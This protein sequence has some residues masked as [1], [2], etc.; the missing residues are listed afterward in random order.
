[1]KYPMVPKSSIY[2]L[3]FL[4][5]A[6]PF[7]TFAQSNALF[8]D[9]KV[10][11]ILIE[12]N[13]ADL[14][15]VYNTGGTDQYFPARFIFVDGAI[16]DTV[17]N[18]GFR[19]RGNTSLSSAKKSFKVAFNTYEPGR[20]YQDVKKINL[21]GNHN[22]PTMIREKLYYDIWNRFGLPER[23]VAF[24]RL[25]INEEY[26][27]L[28]TNL[29]E[30]DKDWLAR[31]YNDNNGN[32]Y[33]CTYPAPLIYI[34]ND[35]QD[36]KDIGS[37]AASGGRAYELQTNELEDDYSDLVGLIAALNE[38]ADDNF[39]AQINQVLNVNLFL[40]ALAVEVICGHW[41][42]YAYN[43]NNYYLYH[44]PA[45]NRFDFI[46]YDADNTMGVDWF[47]I[48]WTTQDPY[49]WINPASNRPLY[50]KMMAVP[51][52]KNQY[53]IYLDHLAKF[54]VLPDSIFPRIDYLHDLI[55]SA[56]IDDVYRTYDYGYTLD[57]FHN[58]FDS[59]IGG[60][61]PYG[62]KPFFENR[63]ASLDLTIGTS[64]PAETENTWEISPN[65]A[66]DFI[67][68]KNIGLPDDKATYV[69]SDIT[70]R[71]V[72]ASSLQ[73]GGRIDISGLANGWY[74]I[75]L[76]DKNHREVVSFVKH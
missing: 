63:I 3:A 58:G 5:L 70:G 48:D 11:S 37:S 42:D 60:H 19:L 16:R 54:I 64:T 8:D 43:Q 26:M 10:S 40:K 74:T 21:N 55:T 27:G 39:P 66:S 1:M 12:I 49:N 28:Y 25:Y 29:E 15:A 47:G 73:N 7:L 61:T 2:L 14:D 53:S 76:M 52:F 32:L 46:S 72:A 41:D 30:M 45:D 59:D 65:P 50:K 18:I 6:S 4:L 75:L 23:R 68:L 62:I 13:P 35:Q 9:T 57:D 31:S 51:E 34:G 67:F 36:Y 71:K 22:D 20:R 38:P 17:E 33:K 24:A 44:D 56:A 69:I